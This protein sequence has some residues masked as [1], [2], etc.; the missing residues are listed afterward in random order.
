MSANPMQNLMA[1]IEA[2]A[3]ARGTNNQLVQTLVAGAFSQFLGTI[4]VTENQPDVEP[5]PEAAPEPALEMGPGMERG[6]AEFDADPAQD[7]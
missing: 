6:P 2:F 4:T 5:E 7:G 1:W 3:V